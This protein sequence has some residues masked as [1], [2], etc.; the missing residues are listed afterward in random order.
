MVEYF[1]R[2]AFG[3]QNYLQYIQYPLD[4]LAK[5]DCRLFKGNGLLISRGPQGQWT[6]IYLRKMNCRARKRVG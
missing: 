6:A 5:T 2:S 1:I 4:L 3:M